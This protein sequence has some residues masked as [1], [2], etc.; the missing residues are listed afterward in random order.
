[1]LENI[2][3]GWA[4]L[5]FENIEEKVSYL[6]DVPFQ[7]LH[8]LKI[9]FENKIPAVLFFDCEGYE[10]YLTI[11]YYESFFSSN[12]ELDGMFAMSDKGLGVWAREIC[13]DIENQL[14]SWAEWG[15]AEF[16]SEEEKQK[17]TE[18]R[19]KDLQSL[20]KDVRKYL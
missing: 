20:L 14:D 13:D 9:A 4:K 6:T 16:E 19:K 17:N 10:I 11:S 12:K 1:M 3:Y 2:G 8:S 18:E 7:T 5:K 15:Y